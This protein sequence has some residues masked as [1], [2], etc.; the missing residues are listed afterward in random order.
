MKTV[1]FTKISIQNF[2]SVGEEAVTV[3]F[4]RGLHVL[5]GINIDK[6][7]R[8][9]AVGKSTVADAL[10]FAIFGETLREIKKD[11][12]TN[13]ITGGKTHVELEFDVDTAQ[14]N[15]KYSIIRTLLPTKV[16]VYK[17]G[18]DETRD[19][20]ANTT[21]Y[22][23]DILSASP[24]VFQNCV[25][26]TVNNAIPFMA[27][28]KTEKRRFIEDI[29]G[30]EVFSKM[31]S[32][33]RNDYNDVKRLH[34]ADNVKLEEINTSLKGY[35]TQQT[36]SL[37][38]KQY[39]HNL[40][41]NRQSVNEQEIADIHKLIEA[42]P[43]SNITE[44]YN[45]QI[46]DLEASLVNVEDLITRLVEECTEQKTVLN[47]KKEQYTKIGSEES[48]CPVCLRSIEEHDKQLIE[49]ERVSIKT[50]IVAIAARVK[51]ILHKI[52]EDKERKDKIKSLIAKTRG[53]LLTANQQIT[54]K[55]NLESNL[56]KLTN[57]Q[58]EL[59]VDIESLNNDTN[60]SL[61]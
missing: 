6:P 14:G 11:L 17:D 35:I 47:H 39:K 51:E 55:A 48:K 36:N 23:C 16:Y 31:I 8:K 20:I 10:Y 12:I 19:S 3:E 54:T 25:I 37:E 7:E 5:T 58:Q 40:Y 22:I 27:K 38:K 32:V 4:N 59:S 15:S 24:A 60:E 49:Q 28:N 46:I 45:N 52:N 53:L 42:I 44:K 30:M 13:N 18:V 50:E 9:N 2:L 33:L 29:F 34:D 61:N 43:D 26:M 57:W 56:L 41:L 1:N 21:K